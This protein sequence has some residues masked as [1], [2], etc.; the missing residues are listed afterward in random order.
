MPLTAPGG[1]FGRG[2]VDGV[3]GQGTTNNT[4]D[5]VFLGGENAGTNNTGDD[6]VGI[7]FNTLRDNS[8]AGAIA[9]GNE[10]GRNNASPNLIAIGNFAADA[11]IP[12]GDVDGAIAIGTRALSAVTQTHVDGRITVIGDDALDT[13]PGAAFFRGVT[14]IGGDAGGRYTVA[15]TLQNTLFVGSQ[16]GNNATEGFNNCA[17]VGS[18]VAGLA[19]S[20]AIGGNGNTG[21]GDL[22]LS[23][24]TTGVN[25]TVAGQG[26][27]DSL[28]TSNNNVIG[29]LAAGEA[30]T[31]GSDNNLIMGQGAAPSF[32][33]D[34][35]V[36]GG[37]GGG[38]QIT[39]A[40]DGNIVVGAGTLGVSMATDNNIV[41]GRGAGQAG[42]TFGDK[43]LLETDIAGTAQTL[44]Y[45][46]INNGNLILGT[47][48]TAGNPIDRDLSGTNVLKILSGTAPSANPVGGG[49]LYVTAGALNYRG[50]AGTIT[51][52]AAA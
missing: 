20:T 41:I 34:N 31:A 45:G 46:E 51:A 49:F 7:G 39:T 35:V 27:A 10:A 21:L 29:G 32:G 28:T 18:R 48:N 40:A 47:S 26:A 30:V 25:N 42:I 1:Y 52:L 5:R 15:T 33:D 38:I 14:V 11:G 17:F 22:C 8:G 12:A 9:Y 50:T 43:F 23:L 2:G 36:L 16:A 3:I 4:G 24:L 37:S 44:L 6:A 19:G 13:Y